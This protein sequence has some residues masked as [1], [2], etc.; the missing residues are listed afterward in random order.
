MNMQ[1]SHRRQDAQDGYTCSLQIS[2]FY[3][4]PKTYVLSLAPGSEAEERE[5]KSLSVDHM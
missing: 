2:T 4:F 3:W 5:H 1:V